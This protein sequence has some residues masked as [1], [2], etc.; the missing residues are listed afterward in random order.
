MTTAIVYDTDSKG[1]Q[2]EVCRLRTVGGRIVPSN[3]HPS[4]MFVLNRYL[5]DRQGMVRTRDDGD[6]FLRLMPA[7]YGGSRLRVGLEMEGTKGDLPGHPFRGNQWEGGGAGDDYP[8]LTDGETVKA[9]HFTSESGIEEFKPGTMFAMNPGSEGKLRAGLGRD[10]ESGNFMSVEITPDV[11][12]DLTDWD[13]S[14]KFLKGSSFERFG[15]MSS[16]QLREAG[17]KGTSDFWDQALD[18]DDVSAA[19][20]KNAGKTN[21]DALSYATGKDDAGRVIIILDP[22]IVKIGT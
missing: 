10:G 5:I 16:G 8:P 14:K 21:I 15:K 13:R 4:G 1:D 19:I 6:E 11:P 2:R 9:Y 12:M 20:I 7:A 17:F 3:S 18:R 22:G